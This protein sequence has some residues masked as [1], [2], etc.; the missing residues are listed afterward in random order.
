MDF[1]DLLLM[2]MEKNASDLFI[3]ADVEPSMKINGQINP[4]I[5]NKLT[6]ATILQLMRS[7]MTEKQW[8]EFNQTHEC[9]FAIT[10]RDKTSR[11]RVSAFQQRDLP[12]MVLRKI[13]TRIPTPEALKLPPILKEL[14]MAKRGIVLFVGGTG[15]GKS[16]SLA[17]LVGY[18]NQSSR[19]HIITI[20]DPIEFVHQHA[21]C[22]ITQREVGIDTE[23]FE[24]ALKNTLRQ[25]PDVILIGEIRSREVME[26]AVAFAE[27]GHLVFATLHANNANQALDRIIHFFGADRHNQLYMDLSLNLKAIVAQQLIPNKDGNGRRAAVEVMINSPLMSDYIRKGEIH[28][29]K[30][31]MKRSRELGMQTFDQ[32]LFD[33]YREGSISYENALKHADA[34]NDLRLQIKLGESD[35]KSLLN[36]TK[37]LS[38]EDY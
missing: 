20:E 13:E 9:N 12:G 37:G 14:C 27:T 30:D 10:D 8:Q 32:A 31:L 11:F 29:L 17:A 21:G 18:R 15:T 33:L 7:I 25:A 4:V 23:S 2:M 36:G 1:N 24:I 22:I 35:A 19:G 6:G 16:T 3:S 5:K 34:P 38:L 28:E 26:Y